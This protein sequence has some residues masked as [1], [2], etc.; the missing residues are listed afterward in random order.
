MAV[1]RT[2]SN[3][4]YHFGRRTNIIRSHHSFAFLA[5][6]R[7]WCIWFQGAL[8]QHPQQLHPQT[9]D[10]VPLQR[11]SLPMFWL[12]SFFKHTYVFH[13]LPTF[14]WSGSLGCPSSCC[15]ASFGMLWILMIRGLQ[16]RDHAHHS[17]LW[18]LPV[19]EL[20][21][22]SSGF[23]IVP[24]FVL[25]ICSIHDVCVISISIFEACL[26]WEGPT[27]RIGHRL[28]GRG[29]ED[30]VDNAFGTAPQLH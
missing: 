11:H 12:M 21:A 24:F 30:R 22:S 7:Y 16:A 15:I 26:V 27:R 18:Q 14:C 5:S 28:E 23:V 17:D 13:C 9:L 8:H 20:K 10:Q 25:F 29:R 1:P 19:K 3:N 6:V 2:S 4:R